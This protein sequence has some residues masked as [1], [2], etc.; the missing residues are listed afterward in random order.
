MTT[1]P[2]APESLEDGETEPYRT[3]VSVAGV[4]MAVRTTSRF[5]RSAHVPATD[6]TGAPIFD[7]DGYPKTKCRVEAGQDDLSRKLVPVY[8]VSNRRTCDN[9]DSSEEEIAERNRK[10]AGNK[11]WARRMRFG[12]DWG[13]DD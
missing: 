4:E 10:G 8:T 7:D 9:C 6:A 2:K 5:S 3:Y 12:D 13:D 1:K 11:S